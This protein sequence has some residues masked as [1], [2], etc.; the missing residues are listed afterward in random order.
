MKQTSM[1]THLVVHLDP[2]E[3]ISLFLKSVL[4][5]VKFH[6]SSVS[7]NFEGQVSMIQAVRSSFK[8]QQN[9]RCPKVF[10]LSPLHF[11]GH[12]VSPRE[13]QTQVAALP[14]N[15]EV[16]S[17]RVFG[18]WLVVWNHNHIGKNLGNKTLV[19]TIFGKKTGFIFPC[20]GNNHTK[21]T[22]I[23]FKG[24]AQPPTRIV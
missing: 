13:L 10:L 7:E 16:R 1:H 8:S 2:T 20:L 4:L 24:V 11:A 23:I 6:G 18:H 19:G 3:T 22:F 14:S 9:R 5:Q 15:R 12:Q 21:L 17:V